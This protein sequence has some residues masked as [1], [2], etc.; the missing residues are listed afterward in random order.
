MMPSWEIRE[1]DWLGGQSL[2]KGTI[3]FHVD[4]YQE[5]TMKT[6]YHSLLIAPSILLFKFVKDLVPKKNSKVIWSY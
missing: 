4:K 5:I 1:L 2:F 3:I 6:T